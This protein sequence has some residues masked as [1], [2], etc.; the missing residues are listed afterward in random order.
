MKV[1]LLRKVA[2]TTHNEY[3]KN[4]NHLL[5]FP[6]VKLHL[7]TVGSLYDELHLLYLK[8]TDSRDGLRAFGSLLAGSKEHH[9]ETFN[10][11]PSTQMFGRHC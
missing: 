5:F 6:I 7:A 9:V 4:T 10:K 3:R 1:P 8:V 2:T 11:E